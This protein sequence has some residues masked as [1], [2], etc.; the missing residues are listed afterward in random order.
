MPA[1]VA[2]VTGGGNV[3]LTVGAAIATGLEV[4]CGA[5]PICRLY[6]GKPVYTGKVNRAPEPH[7][8]AA[9]VAEA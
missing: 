6:L 9:V 4:F 8:L 1:L 2:E 5:A 7:G 3:L